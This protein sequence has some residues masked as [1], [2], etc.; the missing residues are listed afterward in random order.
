MTR[1]YPEDLVGWR[2]GDASSVSYIRKG[3]ITEIP[4]GDIALV[5][6]K[7]EGEDVIEE[8]SRIV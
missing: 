7:V 3:T 6:T 5:E 8:I 1:D 4:T 2:A